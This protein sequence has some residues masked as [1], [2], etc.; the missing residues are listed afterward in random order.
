MGPRHD[1]DRLRD[2]DYR[3]ADL[4][5]NRIRPYHHRSLW[6]LLNRPTDAKLTYL[7][8]RLRGTDFHCV[9]AT[10]SA[11]IDVLVADSGRS[12]PP[13][14][15]YCDDYNDVTVVYEGEPETAYEIDYVTRTTQ[16]TVWIG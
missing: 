13:A 8:S 4:A 7:S 5:D 2:I 15:T 10:T 1:D 12:V 3:H 9:S 14:Q 16:V 6:V 11:G